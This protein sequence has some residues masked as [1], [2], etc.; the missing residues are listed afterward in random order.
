[1]TPRIDTSALITKCQSIAAAVAGYDQEFA[2]LLGEVVDRLEEQE[3]TIR[4]LRVSLC[5]ASAVAADHCGT[6]GKLRA[7]IDLLNKRQ[8]R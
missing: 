4:H 1:M 7:E 6:I 2:K 8:K 3:L 5:E